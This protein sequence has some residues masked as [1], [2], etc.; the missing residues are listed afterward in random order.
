MKKKVCPVTKIV[1]LFSSYYHGRH[2]CHRPA[3]VKLSQKD[4]IPD[5]DTWQ[6]ERCPWEERRNRATIHFLAQYAKDPE[7]T[8]LQIPDSD[9]LANELKLNKII[10]KSSVQSEAKEDAD[11]LKHDCSWL[12]EAFKAAPKADKGHYGDFLPDGISGTEIHLVDSDSSHLDFR[13]GPVYGSKGI[14]KKMGLWISYQRKHMS[15]RRF[16]ELLI[17]PEIWLRLNKE[18]AQRFKEYKAS[19][20]K[21]PKK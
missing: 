3:N 10:E 12:K 6:F 7:K 4:D 2:Q 19:D 20:Y 1:C 11:C 17:S 5:T 13:V 8:K 16:S 15:S 21:A 9:Y 18:I 14:C